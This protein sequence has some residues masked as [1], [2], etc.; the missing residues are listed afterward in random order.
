MLTRNLLALGAI[1]VLLSCPGVCSAQLRADRLY[2]TVGRAIPVH[3]QG[4]PSKGRHEVVLT[5]ADGREVARVAV[6]PGTIDLAP[7]F[8]A[9]WGD[10]PRRVLRAQLLVGGQGVGPPLV[11]QPMLTPARAVLDARADPARPAVVFQPPKKEE[12]VY[13]G[14]RVYVDQR[15]ELTTDLGRIVIELLPESA[16]NS[17]YNF[18]QLV[19]GG[20]YT[21]IPFHRVVPAGRDGHPFVIQAGD[22][23]NTGEGGPGYIFDLE[24]STLKHDLGVVSM[25]R[26]PEPNTNGSQF[27][28]ALSRAGTA[29]L[30]GNY[31]A[32]ARVIEGIEAVNAIASTK[33]Q[34][35]TDKPVKPPRI[36]Q[37]RLIDPPP[38][39]IKPPARKSTEP[40]KPKPEPA[41]AQEPVVR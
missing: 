12:D 26:S 30:D 5:E 14:L 16:P 15:A 37:A 25:A 20:F 23:T 21:D 18:R 41:P 1:V 29:R 19:A 10:Q 11:L 24:Q 32:F 6:L 8:P 36:T 35:G 13:S 9:L 7:L 2:C 27:F 38:I 33:L 17:A 40:P 4:Q 28:I 34:A 39:P 31:C 3:V 22:P